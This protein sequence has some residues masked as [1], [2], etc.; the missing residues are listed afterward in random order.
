[1]PDPA[2]VSLNGVCF[3]FSYQMLFGRNELMVALPMAGSIIVDSFLE[4]V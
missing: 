2:I 4:A 1:M 3:R